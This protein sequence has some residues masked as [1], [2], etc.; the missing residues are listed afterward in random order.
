[1]GTDE[2]GQRFVEYFARLGY[3]PIPGSSLLDKSVPM[4]FVM[5]AGMVQFEKLSDGRR[6]GDH[7]VLIQ[8]CFRYFD[9]E[10]IGTSRTHL[11]LFRMPGAF[12]F[13]PVDRQRT[14][15][16]IW[17]LL[18]EEY[19]FA[20][21]E[22][23]VTYFSGDTID[24][25]VIPADVETASAWRAVGLPAE[26]II[27]LPATS[28]FWMQ[29]SLAV[30]SRN[31]RKRGPTTE[32]FFDRGAEYA[33]GSTCAPGCSCGRYVEFLNTLFITLGIDDH[34]HELGPLEE[35]F[36][37]I[38]IGEER[39]AFLLQ[40][41]DSVYE[42]DKVCPLIQQVRCFSKPLSVDIQGLDASKFEQILVDHLRALLFLTADGAPPPGK[43]GRARL[44]RILIREFLTSQQM[45]GISDPGFMRSMVLTALKVY[46]S[47]ESAS[48]MLMNFVVNEQEIFERT[49]Q[50][51]LYDLEGILQRSKGQIRAEDIVALEKIHGLPIA[52]LRYQLWQKH[53]DFNEEEYKA[54]HKAHELKNSVP[55]TKKTTHS[56][57]LRFSKTEPIISAFLEYYRSKGCQ[58]MP[59]G[60]LIDAGIPMSFVMSAGFT[61]IERC[62]ALAP[63]HARD[64]F[65]LLQNCFRHFDL[66]KVGRSSTHLSFFR[67]LGAFA[68]GESE[69]A[70]QIRNAW[71]LALNV[72]KL[73]PDQLWVTYF[74]GDTINGNVF[75]T[76]LETRDLWM[77]SGVDPD[78]LVGLD[79]G[80][81]FWHQNPLAAG[82]GHESKCG[83]TSEIFFDKGSHLKCSPEC[84]PGCSCGRFVEFLNMLF[85]SWQFDSS[86]G[87][88]SRLKDP[89][90]E[91]VIGVERL[92]MVMQDAPSIFEIDS[93]QP[94][95]KVIDQ[96]PGA[97]E[98]SE[99]EY[100]QYE[101]I[102]VDHL[103]ALVFLVAD[104]APAPNKGGRAFIMRRL[105][106]ETI[107]SMELLGLS[108]PA[109]LPE[110]V[111][112]TIE[113]Y[114][115]TAKKFNKLKPVLLG[116]VR[117][118][119][120]KFET[121][122]AKGFLQVLNKI[123]QQD[124]RWVSG[125][126]VFRFE[127]EYGLP[128]PMLVRFLSHKKIDFN[129]KAY[130]AAQE[131]WEREEADVH[132]R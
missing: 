94:L 10:Q 112:R 42:T 106:R 58:I 39:V 127:K 98:L 2:I 103:R 108:N 68:F 44:M 61:Q 48:S 83:P 79:G 43:G 128:M 97:C 22:L 8:N 51:G 35:P 46:P 3:E 12:D 104:G 55:T 80:T 72:Y 64:G 126:D 32:V 31:S 129:P 25:Q 125:R 15:K 119:K 76:D 14:I 11:S 105:V 66:D 117:D 90:I 88:I 18:T 34:T 6:K 71:K 62:T 56:L 111:D 131:L 30:G 82:R 75:D 78:H 85:I 102:I 19:G 49:V 53:I 99:Q 26:R 74:R 17:T 50:V 114:R 118:E 95:F 109:F 13:G 23:V 52:F 37:E 89:F 93:I 69:K 130:A 36:T 7:F 1:M 40:G 29:T 67:M 124:V 73:T 122:L 16:Q 47:L 20:P 38:V 9:L 116:Y 84:R 4:S 115:E 24:G 65:A 120:K 101:R 92:A 57:R 121:T 63:E 81:N 96:S 91:T 86:T 107:M 33:C 110:L 132:S 123:D 45:L 70:N 54:V 5:S 21:H 87:T 77:E 41:R 60:S 59:G 27:G 28:N 113:L 100:T